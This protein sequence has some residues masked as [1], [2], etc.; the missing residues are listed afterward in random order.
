M[1]DKMLFQVHTGVAGLAM[2]SDMNDFVYVDS[3]YL[4]QH[5]T[6]GGPFGLCSA[7]VSLPPRELPL[8]RERRQ[9]ERTMCPPLA[10]PLV[11]PTI[12][13]APNAANFN[14]G[15]YLVN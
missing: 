6:L 12:L 9:V 15:E 4:S 7:S 10:R 1:V 5:S 3:T 8:V 2:S 11:P 14:V 13:P